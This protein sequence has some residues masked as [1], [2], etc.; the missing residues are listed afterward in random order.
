MFPW[1][2]SL[3]TITTVHSS[4]I[5]MSTYFKGPAMGY[6]NST[7][8]NM[9]TNQEINNNGVNG[10]SVDNR[11]ASPG[12]QVFAEMEGQGPGSHHQAT[13]Q[14]GRQADAAERDG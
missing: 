14:N 11:R 12:S 4:D 7:P 2:N 5:E 8:G 6:I 1:E 13:G 9:E 3:T 10:T